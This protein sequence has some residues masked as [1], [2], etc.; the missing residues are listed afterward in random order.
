MLRYTGMN[1]N[2][3]SQPDNQSESRL[4]LDC[5][6]ATLMAEADFLAEGLGKGPT[7]ATDGIFLSERVLAEIK[8]NPSKFFEG[9]MGSHS[10]E[11]TGSDPFDNML[12]LPFWW[13]CQVS[14]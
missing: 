7:F 14:Q 1:D 4:N 10:R 2:I 3:N 11:P 8:S 5:E 6:D 12:H 13:R 9:R